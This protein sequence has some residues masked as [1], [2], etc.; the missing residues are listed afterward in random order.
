M[1]AG[2]SKNYCFLRKSIW[3]ELQASG[4]IFT[5]FSFKPRRDLIED[6]FV[7]KINTEKI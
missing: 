3:N 6:R 5:T 2:N 4:F 1:G 7:K